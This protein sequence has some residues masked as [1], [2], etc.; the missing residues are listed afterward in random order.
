MGK[1]DPDELPYYNARK[2]RKVAIVTGGNSGIGWYTVLHLYMHGFVVY[3]AGRNST[4]VNKAIKQIKREAR[5]RR[6][7]KE[8]KRAATEADS[9]ISASVSSTGPVFGE[10]HYLPMDLTD[11]KSVEKGCKRFKSLEPRLDVLVNNAGVMALPYLVTADGFD[12]QL[13]TNYVA[14]FLLTMRLLPCIKRCS[15]RVVSVSSIGH[16]LEFRYFSLNRTFNYK[17]D[18]I[19]TWMRYAIAKTASIQFTKLLAIKNPDIL[20]MAVH[21][22]LVMNTNLFSYWTRLPIV[23]IFFWLVFHLIGVFFGVSNEQGAHSTLKCALSLDL[24]PEM[25]NGRYFTTHGV[26]SKASY[27]ASNLNDAASTWIWTMHELRDRGFDV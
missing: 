3:V 14:H 7:V 11:L 17:P 20:C 25:D 19:F 2:V 10:L 13:Q 1:F 23:G 21:P 18:M 26:E 8:G 27:V 5:R 12:V 9:K 22:G 4:R 16:N 6:R 24:E 15:G